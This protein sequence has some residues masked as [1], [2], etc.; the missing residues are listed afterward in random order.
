MRHLLNYPRREFKAALASTAS[1]LRVDVRS[2]QGNF[3]IL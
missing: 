3:P 1:T 2:P